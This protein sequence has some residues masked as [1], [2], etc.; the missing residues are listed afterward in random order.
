MKTKK[1]SQKL[2]LKKETVSNLNPEEMGDVKGGAETRFNCTEETCVSC[3]TL[4][5]SCQSLYFT[6][7]TGFTNTCY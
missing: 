7:P 5:A 4:Q 6:C 1:I 3:V 2:M